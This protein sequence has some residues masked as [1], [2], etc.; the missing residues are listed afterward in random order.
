MARLAQRIER[1]VKTTS[2]RGLRL[3]PRLKQLFARRGHCLFMTG[4]PKSGSTFLV[5]ALAEATGFLP[6]FL[7]FHHLNEQDLYLPK[8]IDSYSMN[9]VSHHH[10]RA[11]KPNLELMREFRIRPVIL[12]RDIFDAL[13]SLR[14]HLENESRATPVIAVTDD[15]LDQSPERQYDFLIDLALPWYIAFYASWAA[16][17]GAGEIDALWLDYED[18]MADRA[19][20]L[21]RIL[22]FYGI[23]RDQGDI[24][25]AIAAA[26]G[27]GE[28]RLH[29]GVTGRG[30][31]LLSE[32]QK[33]RIRALTRHHPGGDFG[34]FGLGVEPSDEMPRARSSAP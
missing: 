7:G 24:E 28:V 20:A 21:S 15:F 32:H 8:L 17:H 12:T 9:V 6:F 16:A 10:T 1:G 30:Q 5:T 26:A 34:G 29:I 27:S 11:T 3:N 23:K 18:V 14:D 19:E 31:A 4:I 25:R 22:D 13:V 33:E 2:L